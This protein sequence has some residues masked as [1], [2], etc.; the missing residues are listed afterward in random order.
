VLE[1]TIKR[2]LAIF[3]RLAYFFAYFDPTIL[4][5]AVDKEVDIIFVVFSSNAG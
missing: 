1:N 4:A 2:F 3:L 5:L